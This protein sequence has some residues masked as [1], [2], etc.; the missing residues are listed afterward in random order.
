[1]NTNALFN[2]ISLIS[3]LEQEIFETNVVEKTKTHCVF[4]NVF[5]F[6]R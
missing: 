2:N 5:P 4:D 6:M 3:S 1:M